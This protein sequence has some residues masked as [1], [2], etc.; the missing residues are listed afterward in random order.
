MQDGK[1]LDFVKKEVGDLSDMPVDSSKET[2]EKYK[3]K[4]KSILKA[5]TDMFEDMVQKEEIVR[6]GEDGWKGRYYEQKFGIS[7]PVEQVELAKKLCNAYV[8]GLCWVMRYYFDGVASWT[9]YY[10]FHYAPFA[11]DL[12][13]LSELK[14]RPCSHL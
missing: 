5:K 6:L 2:A 8:E 10:P 4:L 1:G 9:W 14:V 12:V 3:G 13:D 11:S 7:D